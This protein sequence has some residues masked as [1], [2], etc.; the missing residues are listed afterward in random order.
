MRQ[1]ITTLLV[2]IFSTSICAQDQETPR[3]LLNDALNSVAGQVMD[4]LDISNGSA[5]VYPSVE[6]EFPE[7]YIPPF[8]LQWQQVWQQQGWT[9]FI[10]P[11]D[12]LYQIQFTVSDYQFDV[13]RHGKIHLFKRRGFQ[14][15][16]ELM[17][18]IT[19]I[20]PTQELIGTSLVSYTKKF[21]I[22]ENQYLWQDE[23]VREI[24][25]IRW[26]GTGDNP[27][28]ATILLSITSAVIIYLFYSM[29]G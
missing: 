22:N 24:Y 1:I 19:V 12:S 17:G 2:L 26:Q 6:G 14:G 15:I 5:A 23:E 16:F 11:Q 18:T 20:S 7:E 29:R 13:A 27:G 4:S 9:V 8:A 3:A 25:P 10:V 21:Q 28:L